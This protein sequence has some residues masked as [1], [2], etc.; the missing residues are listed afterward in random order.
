VLY[1]VFISHASEDKDAVV[2]PLAER[3][4]SHHIEV[5]YDEFSLSVGD[6]LRESI[7]RG[8]AN[9]R[10]GIVVLS[11]SFFQKNWARREL[12][13][14]VAREV[15]ED[16]RLL[17]PVWHNISQADIARQSPPLADVLGIRTSLGLA[18]VASKLLQ[19]LRPEESPLITARNFLIERGVDP[20]V[21]SD[22][23]WLDVIG[24][25]EG[26]YRFP[27]LNIDLHWTFPLPF[28]PSEKG[29]ERGINIGWSALQMDWSEDGTQ[30]KICHLTHPSD[31][32]KFLNDW[33]GL[34]EC[35]KLNP[36]ILA[37][38]APQ[39]VIPG[40]DAGFEDLFDDLVLRNERDTYV[41]NSYGGPETV[42]GK[43]P[44]CGNLVAWRH[45]TL[46]NFT[47]KELADSFV[48]AH[49]HSYSRIEYTYVECLTWLLSGDSSW[50]ESRIG[51]RL[52]EG[53]AVNT[54]SG[55][56]KYLDKCHDGFF[57]IVFEPSKSLRHKDRTTKSA[58]QQLEFAMKKAAEK[59]GVS[60][61]GA[62]LIDR[63]QAF[64]LVDIMWNG[65]LGLEAHRKRS[66]N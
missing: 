16:R 65:A 43:P 5:W 32:H 15:A 63:F 20:P 53:I 9:S 45:K 3:L 61:N 25:M 11:P 21:I 2:R 55:S 18:S 28:G 10:F 13:G 49:N 26:F 19:K 30:R 1:D 17:L 56:D 37:L 60:D 7:D 44:L 8:L 42:D 29:K 66:R 39:L 27:D 41:N 24:L 59:L 12:N 51:Q 22:E 4:R 52:L 33:P 54:I 57:D 36:A 62:V 23:W 40:F 50:L 14:L 38:Y 6:S 35:C 34:M 31:V 64:G 47:S 48:R 46:G 58:L